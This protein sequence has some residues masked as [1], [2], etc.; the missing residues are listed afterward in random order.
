MRGVPQKGF[1]ARKSIFNKNGLRWIGENAM[2]L[3]RTTLGLVLSG[4]IL[5][6]S[7]WAFASS[8]VDKHLFTPDVRE[9][10]EA[11][12]AQ[13][14]SLPIIKPDSLS[15]VGIVQTTSERIALFQNKENAKTNRTIRKKTGDAI[16]NLKIQEIGSNYVD[17]ANGGSVTRFKLFSSG[18]NR[19]A[20]AILPDAP[21]AQ[22]P[23]PAVQPS[24]NA[25]GS[26][27]PGA[28]PAQPGNGG[29]LP[30]AS[31]TAQP[32]NKAA[33]PG[34]SSQ[35]SPEA[36]Q[37]QPSP[38]GYGNSTPPDTSASPG[39]SLGAS[40]QSANPFSQIIEQMKQNQQNAGSSGAGTQAPAN[41]FDAMMKKSQ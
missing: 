34:G 37:E 20:P 38:F 12:T 16:D 17:V 21:L 41:P 33:L 8:M 22:G 32:P 29:P 31:G 14:A 4:L 36:S 2:N 27:L 11:A 6:T 40:Q 23:V 3:F 9:K 25:G 35:S 10:A 15:L 18:K 30:A 7:Q 19:P 28:N 39:A 1:F 26:P 24:P 5:L 13:Q